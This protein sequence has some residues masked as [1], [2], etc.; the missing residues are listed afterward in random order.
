M[1]KREVSRSLQYQFDLTAQKIAKVSDTLQVTVDD[2]GF[3]E[4][5]IQDKISVHLKNWWVQSRRTFEI[6]LLSSFSS[7]LMELDF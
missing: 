4:S 6:N 1:V 3:S 5:D 2:G 7:D